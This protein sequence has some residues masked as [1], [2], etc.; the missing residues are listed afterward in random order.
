[1]NRFSSLEERLGLLVLLVV[2]LREAVMVH[3]RRCSDLESTVRLF[4]PRPRIS[5]RGNVVDDATLTGL[6]VV[7]ALEYTVVIA[8]GSVVKASPF[9]HPRLFKSLN[10]GGGAFGI[11]LSVVFRG[12]SHFVQSER[13]STYSAVVLSSS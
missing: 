11:V 12:S 4:L 7:D 6:H 13:I 8:D 3:S 9:S 1:M 5:G 10:G 2:G